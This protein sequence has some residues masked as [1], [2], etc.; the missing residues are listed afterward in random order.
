MNGFQLE[1]ISALSTQK[2]LTALTIDD[3][4]AVRDFSPV[5]G[6]AA[7]ESVM[8]YPGWDVRLRDASFLGGLSELRDI[9]LYS[10]D[11]PDL[12]FLTQLGRVRESIDALNFSGDVRDF[13]AL[14]DI[15]HYDRLGI[16][17]YGGSMGQLPAELKDITVSYLY[18]RRLSGLDFSAMPKVTERLLVYECDCG[19]LSSVP[20]DWT[21]QRIQIYECSPFRS[22]EGLEKFAPRGRACLRSTTARGLRT[23]ARWTVWI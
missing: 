5:G 12:G 18:L 11:L 3:C 2:K 22:L 6:C 4:P 13:S 20:E 9:S 7:L 23:G 15:G 16:D 21:A 19:D 14:A 10:I 17:L 8:I 1:D